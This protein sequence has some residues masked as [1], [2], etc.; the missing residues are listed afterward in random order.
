MAALNA[1]A[2]ASIPRQ[3]LMEMLPG[4]SGD[5]NNSGHHTSRS[6]SG[7]HSQHNWK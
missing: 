3:L 5:G 4:A 1:A 7:G 2:A 6:S